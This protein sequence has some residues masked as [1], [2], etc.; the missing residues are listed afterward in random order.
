MHL[1]PPIDDP[2]EETKVAALE[3]ANRGT[4]LNGLVGALGDERTFLGESFDPWG[5]RRAQEAFTA[6]Q[7]RL[8]DGCGYRVDAKFAD[9]KAAIDKLLQLGRAK[10]GREIAAPNLL[11]DPAVAF[12]GGIEVLSCRNG[13]LFLR[14]TADGAL[15]AGLEPDK[16]LALPAATWQRMSAAAAPLRLEP[17]AGV[18]IC[19]RLRL[20]LGKDSGDGAIAPGS[21]PAPVADWLKQLV[22]AIE[23]AG[24][25]ALATALH[26]RLQQFAAR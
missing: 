26:D 10:T 1:M 25:H 4:F 7:G 16:P 19:D 15:Y 20:R 17:Q 24:D 18:V 12:V 5:R 3:F 6:L 23:E 13:D 22:A 14:W 2:R 11:A 8:G 9:N 21:L